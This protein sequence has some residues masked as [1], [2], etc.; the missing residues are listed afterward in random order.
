MRSSRR[1]SSS[2]YQSLIE[3]ESSEGWSRY[4]RGSSSGPGGGAGRPGRAG[5]TSLVTDALLGSAVTDGDQRYARAL[6]P[7]E[8]ELRTRD[9]DTHL[10]VLR[11]V[12]EIAEHVD[13]QRWRPLDVV[14]DRPD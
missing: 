8:K 7:M 9:G 11:D 2:L 1:S 5:M 4:L 3:T 13:R 10:E 14:P 6:T 12:M